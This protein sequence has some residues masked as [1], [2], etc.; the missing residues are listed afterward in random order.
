MQEQIDK[1]NER[2]DTVE[3]NHQ[4]LSDSTDDQMTSVQDSLDQHTQSIEDLNQTT[5]QLQFPLTQDT[6]DLLNEQFPR[7]TITLSGGTATLLDGRISP[8]TVVL[9]NL[10]NVVGVTYQSI[11]SSFNVTVNYPYWWVAV[12]AGQAVFHSTIA[13]DASTLN[14]VLLI[15]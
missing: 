6:I 10:T 1:L 5:G 4:E 12:T 7:G 11:F 9:F 8:N 15:N 13:S 2:I 14:Y 3:E